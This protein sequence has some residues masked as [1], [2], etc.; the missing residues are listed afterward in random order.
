MRP[1]AIS[2]Q[3]VIDQH[4]RLA[5]ELE[6]VFEDGSVVNKTLPANERLTIHFDDLE[7]DHLSIRPKSSPDG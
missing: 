5:A 2:F 6:I 4:K 7:N 3:L 1:L